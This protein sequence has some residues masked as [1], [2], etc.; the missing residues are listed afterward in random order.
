LFLARSI[1]NMLISDMDASLLVVTT[2]P[3]W[4]N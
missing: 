4:H 2:K 1:A 3:S